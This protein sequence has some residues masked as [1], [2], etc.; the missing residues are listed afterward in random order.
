MERTLTERDFKE[1]FWY[2]RPDEDCPPSS[3]QDPEEYDGRPMANVCCTQTGL[4]ARQQAKLVARWCEVLPSLQGLRFLWFCSRVPQALFDAACSIPNLEGLYVKWSSIKKIDRIVEPLHLRFLHIGSSSQLT[5]I[6]PLREARNLIW[7]EL[8]NIKRIS[9][10]TP[11][12]EMR[13]LQGLAISGSVWTTQVVDTLEPI[14][15]LQGLRYL[16][17]TNLRAKDKTLRPLFSLSSLEHFRAA[18]WWSE[19]EL[20]HLY[21]A[22]PKLRAR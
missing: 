17:I 7:L 8:E 16:S 11:I 22:N 21:E 14:G 9:D 12:G 4:P 10:L 3:I 15:L 5:S 2:W 6:E 13:Q 19:S 20:R 1:G 18:L